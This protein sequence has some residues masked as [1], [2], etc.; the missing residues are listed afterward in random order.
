MK[1][2][3]SLRRTRYIVIVMLYV[4]L[5]ALGIGIANACMVDAT[6]GPHGFSMRVQATHHV[7]EE[8]L[9]SDEAVCH[10]VCAAEQTAAV[11]IKQFGTSSDSAAIPVVWSTA[12]TIVV[13]DP[14]NGSAPS[15]P[16]TW[17]QL[18]VSIRFPRL[19]I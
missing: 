5:T 16:P 6:Q 13:V 17:Y 11:Q 14:D 3:F 12:L 7:D 9:A 8:S 18:P 1:S 19:T 4:W 10:A 15:V 2:I